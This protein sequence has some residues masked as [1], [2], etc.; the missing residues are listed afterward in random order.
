MATETQT[1]YGI[2]RPPVKVWVP[3]REGILTSVHPASGPGTY[4]AVFQDVKDRDLRAPTASESASQVYGAYFGPEDLY[5]QPE[6]ENVRG[7]VRN[8]WLWIPSQKLWTSKGMYSKH[9]SEGNGN[10]EELSIEMLEDL[11]S[12]G[13]TLDRKVRVSADGLVGF[14]PKSSYDLGEQA[15][16]GEFARSGALIAEYGKDAARLIAE[17]GFSD[18]FRSKP[19]I[20]GLDIKEGQDPEQRVSALDGCNGDRL[21]VVGVFDGG[22]VGRAFGVLN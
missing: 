14:A 16:K 11:L 21:G 13:S 20:Y 18:H 15:N 4:Q 3:H 9:D 10:S 17:V 6:F 22:R 12:G 7:I 1:Q 19:W 8:N 5:N 2:D